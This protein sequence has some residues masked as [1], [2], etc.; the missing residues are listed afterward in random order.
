M[1]VILYYNM[2]KTIKVLVYVILTEVNFGEA[3]TE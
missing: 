3:E 2:Y 1:V